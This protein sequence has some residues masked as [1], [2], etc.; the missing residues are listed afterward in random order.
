MTNLLAEVQRTVQGV[1][2][3]FTRRYDLPLPSDGNTAELRKEIEETLI[4]E[5]L[6]RLDITVMSISA[7]ER[8]FCD[9]VYVN[10]ST[11]TVPQTQGSFSRATP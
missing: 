7:M 1:L 10:N 4:S 11:A 8:N 2:D 5:V 6:P 3:I 9:H